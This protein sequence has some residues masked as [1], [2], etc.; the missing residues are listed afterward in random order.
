[1]NRSGAIGIRG[2][3]LIVL[4]LIVVAFLLQNA[5]VVEVQFLAWKWT[6]SRVILILFS[7]AAGFIIGL[8]VGWDLF[9]RRPKKEEGKQFEV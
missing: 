1:M 6:M 8:I 5:Q 9:R 3:V 4:V 7:M 2:V